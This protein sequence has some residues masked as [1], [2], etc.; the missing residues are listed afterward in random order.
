MFG[1]KKI[2]T[3][4]YDTKYETLWTEMFDYSDS[5]SCCAKDVYIKSLCVS[6][7]PEGADK[8]TAI[9]DCNKSKEALHRAIATYDTARR[10]LVNFFTNY[11]EKMQKCS[12]WNPSTR[13][14][15]SHKTIEVALENLI[16]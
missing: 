15:E 5:L 12:T 13:F 16:R 8:T 4:T 11:K 2:T 7:Y 9:S 1:K 3:N 10:D 6:L 14:S